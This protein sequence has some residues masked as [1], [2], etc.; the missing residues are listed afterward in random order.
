MQNPIHAGFF[1]TFNKLEN[2]LKDTSG[3]IHLY[4]A[5]FSGSPIVSFHEWKKANPVML[6]RQITMH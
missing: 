3:E 6:K 4:Q 2:G 1:E 5:P